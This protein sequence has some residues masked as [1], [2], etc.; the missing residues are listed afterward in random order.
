[1]LGIYVKS[2]GCLTHTLKALYLER[3]YINKQ[4]DSMSFSSIVTTL[5]PPYE[6]WFVRQNQHIANKKE[7]AGAAK[8][9]EVVSADPPEALELFQK[10]AF[11]VV[12]HYNFKPAVKDG[13]E[14]LCTVQLPIVFEMDRKFS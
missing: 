5:P 8:G 6:A 9:L 3:G 10:A 13:E 12:A 7:V 2:W 14:V 11:K 4:E 1:M